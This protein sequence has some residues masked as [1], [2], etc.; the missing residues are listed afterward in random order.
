MA[1]HVAWSYLPVRRELESGQLWGLIGASYSVGP[2]TLA[3][4]LVNAVRACG[5][6]GLKSGAAEAE[7]GD[8]T[9]GGGDDAIHPP[10]LITDLDAHPGCDVEPA[11]TI[12][13]NAVGSAIV[14]WIGRVQSIEST[15]ACRFS[16]SSIGSYRS[17]KLYTQLTA[18]I[19]DVQ[20]M[21]GR[22]ERRDAVGELEARID[23]SFFTLGD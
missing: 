13:A 20:V 19:G 10:G 14:G 18:V 2:L 16:E 23:D 8:L 12:D 11:V 3:F 1:H 22:G 4:R 21:T 15:S 7:V 6:Q 5:E 17:G 9:V